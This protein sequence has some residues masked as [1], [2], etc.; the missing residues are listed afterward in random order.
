MKPKLFLAPMA[1]VNNIAF[2]LLC[3]KYGC[4]ILSTEMVSA[5]GLAR[6][7]KATLYLTNTVKQEQPISV[8]LF[9]LNVKY[10]IKAAQLVE[11]RFQHI[12]FNIGCKYR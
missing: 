8:Q 1:G 7:N 4:D 10:I 12:D 11:Q 9:G 3:K 2:R 5:H 6:N